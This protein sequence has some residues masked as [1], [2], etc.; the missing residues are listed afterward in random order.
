MNS[1]HNMNKLLQIRVLNNVTG[2]NYKLLGFSSA[3]DDRIGFRIVSLRLLD[4]DARNIFVVTE[5]PD[6]KKYTLVNE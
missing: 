3:G 4:V 2:K 6:L 5:G 1:S